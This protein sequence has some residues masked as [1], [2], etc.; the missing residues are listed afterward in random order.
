MQAQELIQKL[1]TK[2]T[3]KSFLIQVLEA[4]QNMDYHRLNEL[5]EDE[6]NYDNMKKTPYVHQQIQV[7][8][9]FKEK[10]DTRLLLS[11]NICTGCLCSEPVFVF[12]G[13]TSGHKYA[14]YV[15]FTEGE[16]TDIFRC[17]EQSDGF[18]CLPPF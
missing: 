18:D 3:V 2:E 6:A 15:Q 9:E 1:A 12:T 14:V 13:N 16:I 17:S 7:F 4:F 8:K 5:L 11:T 10:G